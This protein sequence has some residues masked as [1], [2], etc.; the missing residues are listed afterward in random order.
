MGMVLILW[1]TRLIR[2]LDMRKINKTEKTNKRG[3]IGYTHVHVVTSIFVKRKKK[4][5]ELSAKP[6]PPFRRLCER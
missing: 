2:N 6:P 3:D 1:G 4:K 5:L